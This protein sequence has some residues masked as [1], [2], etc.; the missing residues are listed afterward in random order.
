MKLSLPLP[1]VEEIP[2]I[3]ICELQYRIATL[4]LNAA[5]KAELKLARLKRLKANTIAHTAAQ[6]Q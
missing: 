3:E 5:H 1:I 6:E 4:R 2:V